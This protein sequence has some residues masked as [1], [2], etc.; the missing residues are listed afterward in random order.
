VRP[1]ACLASLLLFGPS[2]LH[3]ATEPDSSALR[4]AEELGR[5]A[6]ELLER[7]R[8]LQ[9]EPLLEQQV[10]RLEQAWGSNRPEVV[11]A[12]FTL[13]GVVRR[14]G[15]HEEAL[16][17]YEKALEIVRA[18]RGDRHRHCA[19]VLNGLGI[20]KDEMGSFPQAKAHY[21]E[22]IDILEAGR[23]A[24]DPV[25]A[26]CLNNL[27]LTLLNL[28]DPAG[29][30]RVLERALEIYRS[31]GKDAEAASTL[32]NLADA[33]SLSGNHAES[34]RLQR[35]AFSLAERV[36]GAQDPELATRLEALAVA[37]LKEK[38]LE[39]ARP[40]Y[41][42][43]SAILRQAV[44][45]GHPDIGWI[46]D[47]YGVLLLR[48]GDCDA[49]ARQFEAALSVFEGTLGDHPETARALRNLAEARLRSGAPRPAFETA[50][51]A[52]R[53][54]QRHE[55]L[56][57][58]QLPERLAL[59]HT[60]APLRGRGDGMWRSRWTR[61]S[62]PRKTCSRRGASWPIPAPS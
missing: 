41:E 62:C 19:Q 53:M 45:P 29:A 49:A 36:L 32:G 20:V 16:A 40:L 9:A 13:A 33:W 60:R 56:C 24:S 2:A 11:P 51:R 38:R 5:R 37:L 47:S 12:L 17:L 46:A 30:R 34:L 44:P 4:A 59:Q 28:G 15:D 54:S 3:G 42:R 48:M 8:T 10:E 1:L 35:S 52:E 31:Q 55:R 23:G 14:N 50:L 27:G 61:P 26:P 18:A 22:A 6:A 7:D 21:E 39:E 25:M 57:A 43:A 58:A